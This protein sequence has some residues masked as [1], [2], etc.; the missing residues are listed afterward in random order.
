MLYVEWIF[1]QNLCFITQLEIFTNDLCHF[2]LDNQQ[3]IC[4]VLCLSLL[5]DCTVQFCAS[6]RRKAAHLKIA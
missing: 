3:S 2:I 4:V 6:N 5:R 1:I